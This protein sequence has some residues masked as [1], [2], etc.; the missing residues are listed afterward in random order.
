MADLDYKFEE[1]ILLDI[2]KRL[3]TIY[4]VSVK[5]RGMTFLLGT[6]NVY[7]A[8]TRAKYFQIEQRYPFDKKELK[9][10]WRKLT[11]HIATQ[12]LDQMKKDLRTDFGIKSSARVFIL[13][14]P[15]LTPSAFMTE[16][17]APNPLAGCI[18]F[19]LRLTVC[20][21]DDLPLGPVAPGVELA[22]PPPAAVT[23]FDLQVKEDAEIEKRGGTMPKRRKPGKLI[24][25]GE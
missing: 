18:Q 17:V 1:Q 11:H 3:A 9:R 12:C 5:T 15:A 10:D 8:L 25:K 4:T 2:W 24:L 21:P 23:N 16:L 19:N 7:D 20:F 6:G 22:P 14:D 13:I